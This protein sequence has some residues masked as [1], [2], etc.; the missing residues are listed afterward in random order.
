MFHTTRIAL[1][2]TE[3]LK[4]THQSLTFAQGDWVVSVALK[5]VLQGANQNP[6]AQPATLRQTD[7]LCGPGDANPV[8][9]PNG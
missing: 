3:T 4:R 5:H 6:K 7:C 1:Q 9:V 8:T 2:I